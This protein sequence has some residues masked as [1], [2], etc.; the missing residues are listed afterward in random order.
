MKY[1]KSYLKE[2]CASASVE[3]VVLVVAGLSVS[4]AVGWWIWNT[5]KSNADKSSCQG[6]DSPFCIE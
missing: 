2:E 4:I 5:V 6:S 3:T 1:I